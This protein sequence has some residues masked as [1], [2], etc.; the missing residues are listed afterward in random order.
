MSPIDPQVLPLELAGVCWGDTLGRLW[1]RKLPVLVTIQFQAW[2]WTQRKLPTIFHQREN[3]TH[4][5]LSRRRQG[6]CTP[7]PWVGY[8]VQERWGPGSWCGE[9][10]EMKTQHRKGLCPVINCETIPLCPGPHTV[11]HVCAHGSPWLN[12]GCFFLFSQRNADVA[13]HWWHLHITSNDTTFQDIL[14]LPCFCR[15]ARL[16]LWQL[17]L[18]NS[19][20]RLAWKSQIKSLSGCLFLNWPRC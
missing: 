18:P 1:G 12:P 7:F 5:L 9:H 4:I 10:R 8:E 3:I 17:Q 6:M 13:T 11:S 19:F 20:S 15:Q 16:I 14:P 2:C